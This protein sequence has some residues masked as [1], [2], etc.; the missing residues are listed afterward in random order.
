MIQLEAGSFNAL[1]PITWEKLPTDFVLPDEPLESNLQP[2][3]AKA[4][5]TAYCYAGG[6]GLGICCCGGA[7]Y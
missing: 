4:E 7:S 1:P 5:V 6:I 3:L 2:L